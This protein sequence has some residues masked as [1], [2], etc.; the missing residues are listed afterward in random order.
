MG[1]MVQTNA[2][3]SA[4]GELGVPLWATALG[5]GGLTFFVARGGLRIAGKW[6][7]RPPG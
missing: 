7:L 5:A 2:L 6:Y 1:G 4:C 3:A